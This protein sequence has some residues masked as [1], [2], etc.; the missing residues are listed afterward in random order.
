MKNFLIAGAVVAALSLIPSAARATCT[1]DGVVIQAVAGLPGAPGTDNHGLFAEPVRFKLNHLHRHHNRDELHH[2]RHAG[3]YESDKSTNR[4]QRLFL[5][6]KRVYRSH[7]SD[8]V[9]P[10]GKAA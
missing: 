5:P 8:L 7:Q 4:W 6:S 3:P 1:K 10:L 2:Y 9:K